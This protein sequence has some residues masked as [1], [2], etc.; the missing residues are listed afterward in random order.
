MIH[1]VFYLA[2]LKKKQ[3]WRKELLTPFKNFLFLFIIRRCCVYGIRSTCV[4]NIVW[5]IWFPL[6]AWWCLA[7][8]SSFANACLELLQTG[9]R[10]W[11]VWL[12]WAKPKQAANKAIRLVANV[13]R[14]VGASECCAQYTNHRRRSG[15]YKIDTHQ[16]G[17]SNQTSCG[18]VICVLPSKP[19]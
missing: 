2:E 3:W 6:L 4:A 14:R 11:F 1:M 18:R 10:C 16:S 13:V 15:N 19:F 5:T 9:A 8:A 17:R 7:D 12:R